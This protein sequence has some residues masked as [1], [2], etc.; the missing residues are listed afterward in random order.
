MPRGSYCHA[1]SMCADGLYCDNGQADLTVGNC[2][3]R[4][5]YGQRCEHN[6]QCPWDSAEINE[7]GY[8]AWADASDDY[9]ECLRCKSKLYWANLN[10]YSTCMPKGAKCHRDDMCKSGSCEDKHFWD[11]KYCQ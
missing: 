4:I 8:C 9:Q 1:T 11:A 10:W 5:P 7:N 3:E 6:S 2:V